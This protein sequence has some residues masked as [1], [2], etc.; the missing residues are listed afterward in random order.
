LL[1]QLRLPGD[2]VHSKELKPA[3][4]HY[5]TVER[6]FAN[7]IVTVFALSN[8]N[9]GY[10]SSCSAQIYQLTVHLHRFFELAA[11]R[12]LQRAE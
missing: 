2:K 8:W 12:D 9:P 1:D 11:L 6:V 7:H 5:N 3:D 10:S 4:I